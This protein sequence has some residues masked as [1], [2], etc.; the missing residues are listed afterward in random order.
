MKSCHTCGFRTDNRCELL[1]C[2]LFDPDLACPFHETEAQFCAFCGNV[3][4]PH[5][6]VY[7]PEFEKYVCSDCGKLAY[8]C[9]TCRHHKQAPACIAEQYNGPLDVMITVTSRQG[10]FQVQTQQVNPKVIAQVCPNC[11]CGSPWFCQ[12][13]CACD[14]WEAP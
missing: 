9:A 14:N 1:H 10:M 5:Q 13:V 7:L 4:L 8:T 3:L 12:R 11:K 2:T 6:G